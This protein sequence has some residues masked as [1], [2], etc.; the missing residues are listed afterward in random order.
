MQHSE[1]HLARRRRRRAPCFALSWLTD[2]VYTVGYSQ[3]FTPPWTRQLRGNPGQHPGQH[4]GQPCPE[5][6]P[7]PGSLPKSKLCENSDSVCL[8]PQRF[9]AACPDLGQALGSLPGVLPGFAARVLGPFATSKES[10]LVARCRQYM[11]GVR[12][13]HPRRPELPGHDELEGGLR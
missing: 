1:T 10:I 11:T 13:G 7:D 12:A 3:L 5:P 2:P 9:W 6:A 8:L 4:L